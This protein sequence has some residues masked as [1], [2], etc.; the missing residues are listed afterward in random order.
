MT[1]PK[2]KKTTGLTPVLTAS[3]DE[4]ERNAIQAT[5]SFLKEYAEKNEIFK[6]SNFDLMGCLTQTTQ[7]LVALCLMTFGRSRVCVKRVTDPPWSRNFESLL[8]DF[9]PVTFTSHDFWSKLAKLLAQM[10]VRDFTTSAEDKWLR[11]MDALYRAREN[12]KVHGNYKKSDW[13]PHDIVTASS[14][15]L[16]PE[17]GQEQEHESLRAGGD[18]K[19]LEHSP[20]L[21]D[22]QMGPPLHHDDRPEKAER[23][24]QHEDG[25]SY[26]GDYSDHEQGQSNTCLRRGSRAKRVAA[27]QSRSTPRVASDRLS[28]KCK[29]S[30]DDDRP[31]YQD[32]PATATVF[33]S[34]KRLKLNHSPERR[35]LSPVAEEEHDCPHR[36]TLYQSLPTSHP[37]IEKEKDDASSAHSHSSAF[38]PPEAG[39]GEQIEP[40]NEHPSPIFVPTSTGDEDDRSGPY[41]THNFIE[42][43]Y[44]A[45]WDDLE[46]PD[47]GDEDGLDDYASTRSSITDSSDCFSQDEGNSPAPII[48]NVEDASSIQGEQAAASACISKDPNEKSQDAPTRASSSSQALLAVFSSSCPEQL[49]YPPTPPLSTDAKASAEV[50]AKLNLDAKHCAALGA[51]TSPA[52]T[53]M[54]VAHSLL[55]TTMDTAKQCQRVID[56]DKFAA[57]HNIIDESAPA[58]INLDASLHRLQ[59]PN[60]LSTLI[61]IDVLSNFTI[62]DIHT[63]HVTSPKENNLNRIPR[64]CSTVLVPKCYT[65]Y[66]HF[67]LF[68]YK[69]KTRTIQVLDSCRN[70]VKQGHCEAAARQIASTFDQDGSIA[71][72]WKIVVPKVNRAVQCVLPTPC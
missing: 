53:D 13:T 34:A 12:R 54:N 21:M 26:C 27:R 40:L 39:R 63:L 62:P 9:G 24:K 37:A 29:G 1:R 3:R 32:A 15:L 42:S 20:A 48:N 28:R 8:S 14:E 61:M 44:P 65:S 45:Q 46:Y 31:S 59:A 23:V 58:S 33:W 56:V 35:R 41:D 36:D 55:S 6:A 66:K 47:Y 5:D 57:D 51:S 10:E 2:K 18:D 16:E 69:I 50:T 70:F 64:S 11:I 4:L 71:D 19:D 72:G 52:K 67:A 17:G 25:D 43:D 38:L 68:V 22:T 30:S 7:R 60:K 49:S